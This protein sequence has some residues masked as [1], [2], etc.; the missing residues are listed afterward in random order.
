MLSLS[1][2]ELQQV[3]R[4]AK[5]ALLQGNV[6]AKLQELQQCSAKEFVAIFYGGKTV[7]LYVSLQPGA[8]ALLLSQQ[9]RS[10]T[11]QPS[12][13]IL[14]AKKHLIGQTLVDLRLAE[15]ERT[16]Y[17]EFTSATL[18]LELQNI[19]SNALI[20]DKQNKIL[21]SYFGEVPLV[22]KDYLE[23]I[24]AP[25]F[26]VTNNAN[27]HFLPG[28][29]KE[30]PFCSFIEQ[31]WLRLAKERQQKA[32]QQASVNVCNVKSA[33]SPSCKKNYWQQMPPRSIYSSAKRCKAI[34]TNTKTSVYNRHCS[35]LPSG[36]RRCRFP[37]QKCKPAAN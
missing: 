33:K 23:T 7:P 10:K 34:S 14:Y 31:E 4:E 26:D 8:T 15:D 11:P 22:G 13:F 27:S 19:R 29:S 12:Q 21:W 37:Y 30:Q 32:Q 5:I 9:R 16:V 25:S 17:L 1:W 36:S 18:V 35:R 28:W 6:P 3:V 20:L 2:Q 24:V